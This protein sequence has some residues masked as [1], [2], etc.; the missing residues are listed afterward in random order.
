M[1]K[2]SLNW[3]DITPRMVIGTCPMTPDDLRRIR[4]DAGASAVFSLQHDDCHAY[5]SIDYD[6][7]C[8]AGEELGLVMDRCPI[9]D[10]DIPDMRRHL[11][12]AMATLKRMAV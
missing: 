3:G 11:P 4:D 7:M 12:A 2:W 5:W 10:F 1:W 6:Q 9:R 8:S